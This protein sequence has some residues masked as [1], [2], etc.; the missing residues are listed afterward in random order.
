MENVILARLGG[1]GGSQLR[2][3]LGLRN[4]WKQGRNREFYFWRASGVLA[5][6]KA[7]G[8]FEAYAGIPYQQEQGIA[9]ADQE[10]RRSDQGSF[11][12]ATGLLNLSRPICPSIHSKCTPSD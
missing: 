3:G 4:P 5:A 9:A 11:S 7:Q 10:R 2:T 8:S 6:A 12:A 1:G